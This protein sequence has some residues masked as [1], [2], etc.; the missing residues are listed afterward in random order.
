MKK[1]LFMFAVLFGVV[2]TSCGSA[3]GSKQNDS[4]KVDSA[5]VDTATVDSMQMDTV[6]ADSLHN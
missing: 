5:V 3:N 4:T 1:L 2:F 6:V